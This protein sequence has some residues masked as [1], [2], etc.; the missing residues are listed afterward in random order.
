MEYLLAEAIDI[1]MMLAVAVALFEAARRYAV[2][3]SW[4]RCVQILLGCA[5]VSTMFAWS[6]LTASRAESQAA[7]GVLQGYLWARPMLNARGNAEVRAEA[8]KS[9]ARKQY[10]ST[11]QST[12]YTTAS[13]QKQRY[14]PSESDIAQ[15]ADL[16]AESRTHELSAQ[17][18]MLRY[19][20]WWMMWLPILLLGFLAG[21]REYRILASRWRFNR[22]ELPRTFAEVEG[23]VGMLQ[24]ACQEP[25]MNRALG[26][27][28]EQS[29]ES[30]KVMI[31]ELITKLRDQRAP[32]LL[33]DAFVCL[34]DDE[35]AE[36]VYVFI[37]KC[38]RPLLPA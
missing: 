20:V 32:Q 5:L 37:H 30:R 1:A 35:V 8:E 4:R 33:I 7:T 6:N 21:W 9:F 27:I 19:K 16:L 34:L 18:H 17:N 3:A 23:F 25:E 29:D 36:K 22:L 14:Q 28:L 10:I 31:R 11:G 12:E 13:G 2:Y 26:L 24:A 15:H 38:E